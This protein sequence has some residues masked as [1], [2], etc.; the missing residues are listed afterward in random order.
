MIG[1]FHEFCVLGLSSARFRK[2][3]D[4]CTCPDNILALLDSGSHACGCT[5]R[6]FD[7]F[8]CA[9]HSNTIVI[10]FVSTC[11]LLAYIWNTWGMG[12]RDIY[13]QF[14]IEKPSHDILP[15]M[16]LC[17]TMLLFKIHF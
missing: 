9:R 2:I 14:A 15:A 12:Y 8:D 11:F 7:A 17:K 4:S 1:Y 10:I 5:N 16:L 13:L 3:N 6:P